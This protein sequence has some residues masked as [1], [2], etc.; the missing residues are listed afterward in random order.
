MSIRSCWLMMP[1]SSFISLLVFCLVV[2]SVAERGLS[3]YSTI[4]VDLSSF[5]FSLMGFTSY[6]LQLYFLMHKHLGWLCF[7]SWL[8]DTLSIT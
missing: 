7:V 2:L 6:T 5:P 4:I 8:I 3:K 1:S